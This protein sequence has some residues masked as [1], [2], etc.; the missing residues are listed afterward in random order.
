MSILDKL[1]HGRRDRHARPDPDMAAVLDALTELGAQP[2]ESLTPQQARAQPGLA[3]AVRFRLRRLEAREPSPGVVTR[4]I[5]I[6]GPENGIRSRLYG[7]LLKPDGDPDSLLPL[8]LYFHG[9]TWVTGSLDGWDASPRAMAQLTDCVVI[10]CHYRQAPEHPLP[11]A[12]E[13][14][15]AAWRWVLEHA[16]DFGADPRRI[17]LMGED[18]GANLACATA[19]RARDEGARQAAQMTLVCPIAGADMTTPSYAEHAEARPLSRAMMRWAFRHACPELDCGDDP[20][21]NLIEADL[22]GLPPATVICAEIDP[23]RAEGELLADRLEQA[24]VDVRHKT[25][26]GLTHGFFGAAGVVAEAAEAQVF[27]A[28]ELGRAFNA[29]VLAN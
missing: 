19:M 25:F 12:Y 2:V 4:N 5:T 21:V 22:G 3:E 17:A 9:G 1:F 7:P 11:A 24:A 28:R 27:A 6:P 23:L 29:S 10:S 14:A 16:Q 26:H 15:F 8:V 13:D 20:R 18:S